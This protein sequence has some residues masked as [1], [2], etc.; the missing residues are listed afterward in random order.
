MD[1]KKSSSGFLF[2]MAQKTMVCSLGYDPTQ[3][4]IFVIDSCVSGVELPPIRPAYQS[5]ALYLPEGR[6]KTKGKTVIKSMSFKKGAIRTKDHLNRSIFNTWI[7]KSFIT[8]CR[9]QN[10]YLWNGTRSW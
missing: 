10:Y 3:H 4:R 8:L 1:K 6:T 9:G 7:W 5:T 2:I